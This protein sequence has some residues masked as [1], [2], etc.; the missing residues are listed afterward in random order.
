MALIE[1]AHLDTLG[2]GHSD[3]HRQVHEQLGERL[4]A[5]SEFPC[6]FSQNAFKRKLICYSFVEQ[7]DEAGLAASAADLRQ[8]TS[9][10]RQ[11]NG[12][13]NTARPLV[14]AFS[15]QAARF[16]TLEQY[17]A[18]G[19]QVLQAWHGLDLEDWPNGVARDPHEPFWSMC[20]DSMQLFVNM[21]VPLHRARR[22]RN[23]GDHLLFIVNPRER[24]DIVAGNTP[25]GR[26]MRTHIRQRVEHY[27]GLAHCH[28]LGSYQA[29]EIEWWQYGIVE[30]NRERSDRCPF[31]VLTARQEA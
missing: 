1:Q 14:V 10:S 24:F 3:W 28:Q 29:G 6:T 15:L 25:E 9:L 5:P 8:Y 21:S 2:P 23:L 17:H 19:W 12:S 4:R 18:F 13:I 22:S 26:A 31:H 7:S 11:W 30:E 20:F 16:D 27:D